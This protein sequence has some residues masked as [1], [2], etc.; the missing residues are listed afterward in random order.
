MTYDAGRPCCADY[1]I[2]QRRIADLEKQI[3]ILTGKPV[4]AAISAEEAIAD[5][6]ALDDS[7]VTCSEVPAFIEELAKRGYR[8]TEITDTWCPFCKKSHANGDVCMGR[9]P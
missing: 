7:P 1:G 5:I 9:F 6:F 3:G 2:M 4:I 8:L